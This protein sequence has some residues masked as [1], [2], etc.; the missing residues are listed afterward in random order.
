MWHGDNTSKLECEFLNC[1]AKL[2]V[3][4]GNKVME[5]LMSHA[6]QTVHGVR[7]E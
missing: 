7:E 1:L 4:I 2:I 5:E 3:L 6:K